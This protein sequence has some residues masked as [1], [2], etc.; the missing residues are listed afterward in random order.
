MSKYNPI[1]EVIEEHYEIPQ[2]D[3]ERKISVLLPYDYHETRKYYPVLYLQDGQNLFNPS[4]P[5]G[6]WAIDK[7]LSKLA[8]EGCKDLIIVAIDHGED[9]RIKEYLP[10][11][12]AKFGKGQGRV[13]IDFLKE[14]LIPHVNKNYRVL[15]DYANMGI[16]GSSMGGLI[17][18]YAGLTEPN[19]FGKMMIFSPSLWLSQKIFHDANG[20]V[21]LPKSKVY[22]YGGGRESQQHLPNVK[23]LENILRGKKFAA[24]YFH[25]E[26]S[27]NLEGEHSERY[28]CK[29]FPKAVQWLYFN[30]KRVA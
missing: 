30:T 19:V 6:D 15:S 24:S 29:E 3:A 20:L 28:W 2:F 26:V 4:A 10:Y 25:V 16:G 21:P 27:V 22:L 13:Y 23:R 17:S 9:E 12:H 5:F 7:S 8:E 18:L 11:D 14:K 1:I